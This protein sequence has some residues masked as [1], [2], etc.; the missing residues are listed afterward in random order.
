MGCFELWHD[1]DDDDHHG[2]HK[3]LRCFPPL[4]LVAV[5][6]RDLSNILLLF[7]LLV[8]LELCFLHSCFILVY[9]FPQTR[10]IDK[11]ASARPVPVCARANKAPRHCCPKPRPFVPRQSVEPIRAAESLSL[12][13]L[14]TNTHTHTN[15]HIHIML[16]ATQTAAAILALATTLATAAVLPRAPQTT[17]QKLL[18]GVAGGQILTYDFDGAQFALA[19]NNTEAG[20][21]P[22]WMLPG[23]PGGRLYAADENSANLRT[24]DFAAKAVLPD[25]KP[26]SS[27]VGSQGVVS[28]GFNSDQTRLVGGSYSFGSVDIWDTTAQDG[29]LKLVKTLNTT[30]ELGP[31]QTTHR[32]HD[33]QL[34]PTGQFF[35][36]VDLG[37]DQVV[38]L[39]AR[40]DKYEFVGTPV[41][42]GAGSGPRHG[43]FV[44]AG[45]GKQ[46]THYVVVTELS[47][48][49]ILYTLKYTEA[50]IEFTE[51]DRQSTIPAGSEQ[52]ISAEGAAAG[53][54]QVVGSK[55]VYVSNRRTGLPVGDSIVHFA[56]EGGGKLV[57]KQLV[58]SGGAFP[59]HFSFSADGAVMFVANQGPAVNNTGVDHALAAFAR[60]SDSGELSAK[61]FA[62]LK[63]GSIALPTMA[64][65]D[66]F[67]GPQFVL[68][69]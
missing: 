4:D 22:S 12:R 45:S 16:R 66:Q 52:P 14:H 25:A 24:F 15:T 62:S 8:I 17:S 60:C 58:Q 7:I 23:K 26:V 35:A 65:P 69:I 31:K 43:K 29:T 9:S 21:A 49:L 51:V 33:V 44:T 27:A 68:P 3:D 61:P 39:D 48:Q 6:H 1:G 18:V 28:L 11:K 38:L 67:A 41:R 19:S 32:A 5:F 13:P 10:H 37:G 2:Q 30:G 36:V 63:H 42:T 53:E 57:Y 56:L 46:A 40:A 20:T 64:A 34:D 47:N 55:D 59:R 50:A 54:V